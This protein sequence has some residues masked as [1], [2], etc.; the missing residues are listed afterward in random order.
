MTLCSRTAADDTSGRKSEYETLL[1]LRREL[2]EIEEREGRYGA[3]ITDLGHDI[4]VHELTSS[5]SGAQTR[6]KSS[7]MF[8]GCRCRAASSRGKAK[9]EQNRILLAH[10]LRKNQELRD[11]L[12]DEYEY[13]ALKSDEEHERL[14]NYGL[15]PEEIKA[16]P[17]PSAFHFSILASLLALAIGLLLVSV[18]KTVGIILIVLAVAG[19]AAIFCRADKRIAGSKETSTTAKHLGKGNCDRVSAIS[20]NLY[21]T[22]EQSSTVW[23]RRSMCWNVIWRS[24]R[25]RSKR[26]SVN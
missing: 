22:T 19:L 17:F 24:G 11:S 2:K 23:M 21:D 12:L 10:S 20:I 16:R 14:I 6:Q 26:P 25:L 1:E 9:L 5:H 3:R 15:P 18:V 8:L 7:V 13:L 4:T